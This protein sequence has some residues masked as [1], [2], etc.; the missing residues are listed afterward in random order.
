MLQRHKTSDENPSTMPEDAVENLTYFRAPSLPHLLAILLRPPKA[1]P[2]ED[3]ALLVVDSISGPFPSY[4]LNP[5]ELRSSLSQAGITDKPQI[6]W[7]ANRKWNVTSDLGNALMKLATSHGLAAFVI[8][9]THTKIKGQPRATLC[10]VVG[11]G[12]WENNIY[13]RIVLYRDFADEERDGSAQA[14]VRFAEVMKRTGKTLMLR[15]EENIVPFVVE[16]VGH[17]STSHH[18]LTRVGWSP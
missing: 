16:G 2:P 11:G 4:F 17:H 7:L 5:T 3:T 15:R 12:S 13:T 6:Q 8:N 18:A 10:P 14:K 1:F 9:Q